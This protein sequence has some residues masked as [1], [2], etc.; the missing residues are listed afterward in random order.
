MAQFI[1]LYLGEPKTTA[2]SGGSGREAW[3]KWVQSLGAA[4]VNPG[5]PMKNSHIVTP[6][7]TEPAGDKAST[8]FTIVDAENIEAAIKMA[9]GCP[10]LEMGNLEVAELVQMG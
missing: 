2:A 9:Q 8:G 3:G 4:A 1:I 5:T 10:Y 7:K 6:D